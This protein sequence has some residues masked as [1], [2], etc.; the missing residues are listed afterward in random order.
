MKK[1]VFADS[2]GAGG[3][4]LKKQP[5]KIACA[6]GPGGL[7][8]VQRRVERWTLYCGCSLKRQKL[9][10]IIS[11]KAVAYVRLTD[12]PGYTPETV[13]W[14]VAAGQERLVLRDDRGI[15]G[16]SFT[17]D[18]TAVVGGVRSQSARSTTDRAVL[19]VWDAATGRVLARIEGGEGVHKFSPDG[20]LIV[21]QVHL[22]VEGPLAR[23]VPT[24]MEIR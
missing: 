3:R 11:S 13:L 7:L 6:T 9:S 5:D 19:H 20:K 17:P 10:A 8:F 16:V 23:P 18:G 21:L 1:G 24:P 2:I 4:R 22:P 14:D 12:G 15:D